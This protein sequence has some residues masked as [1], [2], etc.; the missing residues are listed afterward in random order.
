MRDGRTTI[1]PLF[2]INIYECMRKMLLQQYCILKKW[3]KVLLILT[4]CIVYTV[5]NKCTSIVYSR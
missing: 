2:V 4:Y 5:P 1:F 3:N